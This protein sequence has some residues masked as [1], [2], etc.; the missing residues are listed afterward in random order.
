MSILEKARSSHEDVELIEEAAAQLLLMHAKRRLPVPVD[1]GV[2]TLRRELMTRSIA[3][4]DIHYGNDSRLAEEYH[5][6][7]DSGSADIW[8]QFYSKVKNLK[9]V[10]RVSSERSSVCL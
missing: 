9:D 8:H 5:D 10:S 1:H 6:K 3:L 2:A 7:V 4:L